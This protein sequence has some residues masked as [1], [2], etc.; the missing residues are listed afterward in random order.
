MQFGLDPM[1]TVLPLFNMA[2]LAFGA[3]VVIILILVVHFVVTSY[4]GY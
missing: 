2:K 1:Q 4:E 3:V